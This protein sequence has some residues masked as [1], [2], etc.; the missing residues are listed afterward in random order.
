[1]STYT[2]KRARWHR[3]WDK[4]AHHYDREM[5]FFERI[6]FRDSRS[7]RWATRIWMLARCITSA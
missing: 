1:M 4:K 7:S 2:G 6:L 5:Q 3:Y